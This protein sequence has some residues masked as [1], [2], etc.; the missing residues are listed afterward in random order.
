MLFVLSSHCGTGFLRPKWV[1]G[2]EALDL[3]K[4]GP[5]TTAALFQGWF[6]I[7]LGERESRFEN[8]KVTSSNQ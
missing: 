8:A 5:N 3:I 4:S 6:V 2:T 1:K 7:R